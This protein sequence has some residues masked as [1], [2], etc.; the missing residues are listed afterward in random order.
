[1]IRFTESGMEFEFAEDNC[2]RIEEDPLVKRSQCKS[3]SNNMAC[4]CISFI[5]GHHCF[6]EA[7]RSVPR[8][9]DG[10]VGVVSLNGAPLP[11]TWEI[12]DNYQHFLRS[13]CKKFIDS[14][15]ILQAISEGRHGRQRKEDLSLKEK[16][17]NLDRI[18]F[19]LIINFPVEKNVEKQELVTLT[20]ALKNEMRPF[21]KIWKIHDSSVKV[22]LPIDAKTKLNIPISSCSN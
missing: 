12:Y 4:E 5:E 22:L 6:I 10:K 18:R 9:A 17:V 13:I 1:M 20:E 19:I 16:C 2:F 8:K 3:T 21:L 7:K 15:Y 11:K 14:F